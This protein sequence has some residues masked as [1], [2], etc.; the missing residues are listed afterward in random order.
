MR[1]LPSMRFW[2]E[3]L[4]I[5]RTSN[6]AIMGMKGMAHI[7]ERTSRAAQA[8]AAIRGWRYEENNYGNIKY[9]PYVF[10]VGRMRL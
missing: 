5:T 2:Q 4:L 10:P 6:A 7:V 8:A 9:Y 3:A 1:T